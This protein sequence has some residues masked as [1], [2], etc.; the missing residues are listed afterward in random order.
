LNLKYVSLNNIVNLTYA[1]DEG[2]LRW[3]YKN[4]DPIIKIH[5][6]YDIQMMQYIQKN[7]AQIIYFKNNTNV[8]DDSNVAVLNDIQSGINVSTNDLITFIHNEI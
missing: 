8:F 6:N 5:T 7:K 1:N 4:L 2:G 3:W